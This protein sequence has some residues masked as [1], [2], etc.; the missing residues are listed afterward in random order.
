[1]FQGFTQLKNINLKRLDTS[2]VTDMSYMFSGTTN[3]KN[4]DAT[5]NVSKVTNY[6]S[7]MDS[8]DLFNK[9]PWR[10]LFH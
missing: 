7:F 8:T 5:F 4:V 3:L 10:F 2:N 1:M 6:Q 9:R